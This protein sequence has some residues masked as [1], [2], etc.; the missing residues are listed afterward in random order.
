[1]AKILLNSVVIFTI[2][3]SST[4]VTCNNKADTFCQSISPSSLG[5]P[6]VKLSHM[7]M[8]RQGY[9]SVLVARPT[10]GNTNSSTNPNFGS[11]FAIDSPLTESLDSNSKQ[12]GRLEGLEVVS[13]S[14]NN[15]ST[16]SYMNHIVFTRGKCSGSS[17]SFF[18]IITDDDAIVKERPIVI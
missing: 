12:V 13:S 9:F 6:N 18:G 1:M 4:L 7:R 10:T 15:P 11:L 16:T 14:T 2:F 5:L 3:I 17:L 8:F